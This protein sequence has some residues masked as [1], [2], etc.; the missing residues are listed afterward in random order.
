MLNEDLSSAEVDLLVLGASEV[1]TCS[2]SGEPLR[3]RRLSADLEVIHGGAVAIRAG[4]IIEVGRTDELR[5]RYRAETVIDARGRLVTP[6]LVD[7]HT[8]LLYGGTRHDDWQDRLLGRSSPGLGGG[9]NR[10]VRAT[11]ELDADTLRTRA[12]ADLDV[13]LANGTTTV[14]AKTG[15]GLDRATELRMLK[16]MANLD[17][18]LPVIPTYLGAHVLPNE[19]AEDR[20]GYIRL[21]SELLP[22]AAKYA[23]YCDIACDPAC[24]TAEECER[25]ARAAVERG[26]RLRVHGDQTGDAGGVGFAA[27]VGASSVDHLDAVSPAGIAA[28]ADSHTIGIVFPGVTHH[29]LDPLPGADGA[30]PAQPDA[31]GW[32]QRIMDGGAALALAT[33]Y[34]PGTCPMPSMQT[35]MQLAAR[36]YRLSYAEIWRMCTINAAHALDR[37]HQIG[38]IEPGKR[39]DLLIWSVPEHGMP[40]HR[41]GVNLVNQVIL[42]GIP[43]ER[44]TSTEPNELD[45]GPHA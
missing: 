15:Y 10:T 27:R 14:E 5:E 8:H 18:P 39:A 4:R 40:V 17:H 36:L 12:C 6:G 41:F 42:A 33:D 23:E 34:N 30:P 43:I 32:I 29:M 3:G 26:L 16:V 35:A 25:I 9:I 44:R 20:E 2:G 22:E 13:M 11:R 45:P 31:P 7:A 28:L 37:A 19:F 24:F 21:V 38:S 1:L